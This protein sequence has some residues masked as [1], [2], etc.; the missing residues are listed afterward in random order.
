MIIVRYGEIGTK[1]KRTRKGIEAVL[2]KNI[3]HGLGQENIRP[4]F[5]RIFV[6]SDSRDVAESIAQVC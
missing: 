2:I 4:E 3:K 5:G 1:S 6:E